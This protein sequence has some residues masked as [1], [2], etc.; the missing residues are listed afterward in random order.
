MTQDSVLGPIE[1]IAYTDDVAELFDR[2]GLNH[3]LFTDDK[4][5]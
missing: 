1:F 3:H 4:Q 2:H 5:M